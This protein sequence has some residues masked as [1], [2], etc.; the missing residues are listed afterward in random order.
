M[1][2]GFTGIFERDSVTKTL[3]LCILTIGAFF[4]FKLYQFSNEI[5]KKTS[6]KIS[7]IFIG[8]SIVLFTIALVSLIYSLLNLH[9]P[10]I[11]KNSIGIH[12][13]SSVFDIWWIAKVR[14]SMNIISGA[15]KGDKLW[16]NPFIIAI[17]HVI[18]MQQTINQGLIKNTI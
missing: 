17:F 9:D 11:L 7:K 4:I 12:A 8:I 10:Q 5:N 2:K 18:Y 6:L 13:I 3:V 1:T 15:A 16:L 14:N